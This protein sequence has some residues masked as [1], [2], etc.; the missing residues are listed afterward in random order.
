MFVNDEQLLKQL[1][2]ILVIPSG[3]IIDVKFVFEN[4]YSPISFNVV[5]N[6]IFV[7]CKQPE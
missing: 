5:G 3:I 7:N 2:P 6:V 1:S 4:A